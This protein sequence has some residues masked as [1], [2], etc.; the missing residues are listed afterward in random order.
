[1]SNKKELKCEVNISSYMFKRAFIQAS[2]NL[3]L[4]GASINV[5]HFYKSPD[6]LLIIAIIALILCFFFSFLSLSLI[7]ETL[8]L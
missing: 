3:Q 7:A 1:M 6:H 4:A 2:H 5:S 8:E